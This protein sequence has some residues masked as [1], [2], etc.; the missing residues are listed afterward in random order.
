MNRL[1][2]NLELVGL[3]EELVKLN[4]EQRFGQILHNYEFIKE[5]TIKEVPGDWRQQGWLN[6]F[7]VESVE[8][9]KRVYKCIKNIK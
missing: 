8:L 5:E 6:E 3:L 2:A 7:N 1:E 4:P 9:L